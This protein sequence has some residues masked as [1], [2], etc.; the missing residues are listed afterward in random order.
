MTILIDV[1]YAVYGIACQTFPLPY[2]T[3]YLAFLYGKANR[4]F[5]AWLATIT[6]D[7]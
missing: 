1:Q 6:A 3:V 4:P 5:R 7:R 2:K